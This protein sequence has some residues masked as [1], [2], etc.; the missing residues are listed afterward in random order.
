MSSLPEP[1]HTCPLCGHLRPRVIFQ[2]ATDLIHKCPSCTLQFAHTPPVGSAAELY[3][4]GYFSGEAE[5]G[6]YQDYRGEYVSHHETFQRR[7]VAA[8][9]RLGHK[10]MLL[11]YGCALG[12]LGHAARGLGWDVIITDISFA[13]VQRAVAEFNLL[14]FVSDLAYPPLKP[15]AFDL[16]TLYDVIEHIPEPKSILSALSGL[17]KQDGLLHVT[18]PDVGSISAHL[19]GKRWYHYKPREH[20][21]YFNRA[22][23]PRI[24]ES[25]GMKV[26]N[27]RSA[28]SH[29]TLHDILVR[30]RVYSEPVATFALQAT[31][32]LGL[33]DQVIKIHIGEMQ[34]WATLAPHPSTA[35]PLKEA[36]TF[37]K[38][39]RRSLHRLA[40]FIACPDCRGDLVPEARDTCLRCQSCNQ[41]YEVRDR[42]PILLP[43]RQKG[44]LAPAA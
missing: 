25:C 6:G 40:A 8:E 39:E 27:V 41:T 2:L 3:T 33:W 1:I 10:G 14:G 9:N 20:L 7:L 4:A 15:A 29:M 24:I 32:L 12:H 38:G 28:P 30:L 5:T 26:V 21:Y 18:T 36:P 11:D 31:R 16:I 22:T 34:A 19:L 42:V 17:L 37:P 44:I 35:E 23:L 43:K 13:A